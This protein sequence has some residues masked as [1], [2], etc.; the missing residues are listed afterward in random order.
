MLEF[1]KEIEQKHLEGLINHS[2]NQALGAVRYKAQ[3]LLP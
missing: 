1:S 2:F 3:E